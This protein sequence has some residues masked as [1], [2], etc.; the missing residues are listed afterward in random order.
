[1]VKNLVMAHVYFIS[2]LVGSISYGRCGVIQVV[3]RDTIVDQRDMNID[4][5]AD[6]VVQTVC[7]CEEL[8]TKILSDS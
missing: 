4:K 5:A 3:Y 6:A 2:K 8:A 1:M 7:V